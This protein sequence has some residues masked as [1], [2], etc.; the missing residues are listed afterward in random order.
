MLKSTV[1]SW[2]RWACSTHKM[3]W[4]APRP[5]PHNG[6]QLSASAFLWPTKPSLSHFRF[7]ETATASAAVASS[8]AASASTSALSAATTAA[9]SVGAFDGLSAR[10]ALILP[11]EVFQKT[12]MAGL[13]R[14]ADVLCSYSLLSRLSPVTH[15]VRGGIAHRLAFPVPLSQVTQV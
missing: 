7:A 11:P 12:L 14:T 3:G 15:S 2:L 13:C 10:V 9:C 6:V 8:T 5:P 4:H 1:A